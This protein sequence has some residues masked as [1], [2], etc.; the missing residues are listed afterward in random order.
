MLSYS[1]AVLLVCLV[2]MPASASVAA[3]PGALPASAP[4][5]PGDEYWA[6][7]YNLPGMNRDVTALAF[8]PDGSLYAGG[9]FSIAGG[10]AASRIARWTGVEVRGP[11][12]WFPI[13]LIDQ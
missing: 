3:V 6:A 4:A 10:V 1:V 13:V 7:G 11:A 9:S 5:A 8:G 2:A 12:A